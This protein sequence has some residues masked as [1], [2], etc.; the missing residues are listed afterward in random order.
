MFS[1]S[2]DL[3]SYTAE[4]N[5]TRLTP[6][7]FTNLKGL[8]TTFERGILDPICQQ[9]ASYSAESSHHPGNPARNRLVVHFGMIRT[10]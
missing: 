8:Q 10:N 3:A 4:A 7:Y 1:V 5:D 2:L 9:S 6:A